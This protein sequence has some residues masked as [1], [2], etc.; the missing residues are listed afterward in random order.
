M[1]LLDMVERNNKSFKLDERV[2]D[3]L[4]SLAQKR[5]ASV[6]RYLE[7]LLFS[8]AKQEGEIPIDAMSIGDNP[9]GKRFGAGRKITASE[10]ES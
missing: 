8:H 5:N 6:N 2:L 7:N 10:A 4:A 3:A 9:E 1:Y